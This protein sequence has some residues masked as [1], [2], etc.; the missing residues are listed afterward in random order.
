[1]QPF[2]DAWAQRPI[3]HILSHQ[4]H[5]GLGGGGRQGPALYGAQVKDMAAVFNPS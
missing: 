3:D 1:M 5:L 4:S 2:P